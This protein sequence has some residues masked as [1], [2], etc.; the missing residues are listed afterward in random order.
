MIQQSGLEQKY[1]QEQPN[2]GDARHPFY[3]GIAMILSGCVCV[4]MRKK[5]VE[6]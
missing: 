5:N 6:N 2:T 3:W 4:L 1:A